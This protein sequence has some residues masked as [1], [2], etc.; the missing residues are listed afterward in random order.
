RI[1]DMVNN[2]DIASIKQ[3]ITQIISIINDPESGAKD[4]KNAIELDPPLSAKV[5]KLANSALYG[6]PKTIC[7]IQEAIVCIGFEAVKELALS[8]KIGEI[9]AKE[10]IIN[11]YSRISLW[12]H[13]VAIAVCSKLIY[14][15]EFREKGDNAYAAGLLHDIGITVID[16][17][18]P[19]TFKKVIDE[20]AD[21][22]DNLYDTE[23]SIL[24]YNHADIGMAIAKDWQ[25]PDELIVGLGYHH[26]PDEADDEFAKIAYIIAAS[27]YIC[28]SKNIGFVE[29]YS[30]NKKLFRTCLDNLN[31]K[32]KALELIVEEV[33]EE[34]KNMEKAGWF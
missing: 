12:K 15:R 33:E 31:M 9:F 27:D 28:Q 1:V 4:L 22:K 24:G 11:G 23:T 34:I 20:C 25:F 8:Q 32:E 7:E 17:F 16:Q 18:L 30:Q 13:S 3:S 10:Q 5:L 21:K 19:S 26:N 6:Y 2:S 14:R 29:D